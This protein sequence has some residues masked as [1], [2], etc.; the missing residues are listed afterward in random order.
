M[1]YRSAPAA[2]PFVEVDGGALAG[3]N[4]L[5]TSSGGWTWAC[6]LKLNGT[7]AW[8]GLGLLHT[9][10][11]EKLFL[12]ELNPSNRLVVGDDQGSVDS[13]GGGSPFTVTETTADI[14]LAVSW[15]GTDNAAGNMR[16]SY[17]DGSAPWQHTSVTWNSQQASGGA[18]NIGVN[19][20]FK[21]FNNLSNGDDANCDM[22]VWGVR[23]GARSQAE[24]EALSLGSGGYATWETMFDVA[25]SI[26]LKFD[27]LSSLVDQSGGGAD[28]T[29]RQTT[30]TPFTL[31]SDPS[32]FYSAGTTNVDAVPADGVGDIPAPAVAG[33]STVAGVPAAAVGDIPAPAVSTSADQTVNAVP[34]DGVGDA[35]APAVSGGSTVAAVPMAGVGDVA[36]SGIPVSVEIAAAPMAASA[37]VVAATVGTSAGQDVAAQP[38][39]AVGDIPAPAL[40]ASSEVQA[41]PLD[42]IGDVPAP[43]AGVPL[44]EVAAQPLDAQGDIPAPTFLPALVA[45]GGGIALTGAG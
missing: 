19:W 8:Q 27:S 2:N 16:L 18:G 15:D 39:D 17:F 7:G 20:R 35:P 4:L 38:A 42:G 41:V 43:A 33:D 34:A 24:I 37:D 36:V 45:E 1:A 28:E 13:S 25:D 14:I 12:G 30:G 22:Y 3:D 21:L 26:L 31:V 29:A 5:N 9:G 11:V 23:L 44:E 40:V 32:G 10:S 6:G